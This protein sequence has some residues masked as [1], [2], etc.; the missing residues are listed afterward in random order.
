MEIELY[1]YNSSSKDSEAELVQIN[2]YTIINENRNLLLV[3]DGNSVI[4]INNEEKLTS[5]LEIYKVQFIATCSTTKFEN[6]I[7]VAFYIGDGSELTGHIL[8]G[9]QGSYFSSKD[10]FHLIDYK[11][12]LDICDLTSESKL[13]FIDYYNEVT[14]GNIGVNT[15]LNQDG[16][17]LN[18]DNQKNLITT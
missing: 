12:Y 4:E 3:R 13:S 11:S 7:I 6:E 15:L 17:D 5:C 1:K 14:S 18:Y 10:I 16:Q 9:L 8:A 2:K